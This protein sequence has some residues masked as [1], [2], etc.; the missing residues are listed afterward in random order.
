MRCWWWPCWAQRARKSRSPTGRTV[1]RPGI[2]RV[3]AANRATV[4]RPP[5]IGGPTKQEGVTLQTCASN[6]AQGLI[7]APCSCEDYHDQYPDAP[8]RE[9]VDE[10]LRSGVYDTVVTRKCHNGGNPQ[11]CVN[12]EE[13]LLGCANDF[14]DG[15]VVFARPDCATIGQASG[16]AYKEG[17]F[18][19]DGVIDTDGN[20]DDYSFNICPLRMSVRK[21]DG[22]WMEKEL[23]EPGNF[24]ARAS[25]G[26]PGNPGR[27]PPRDAGLPLLLRALPYPRR[28]R[29]QQRSHL[30]VPALAG[31]PHHRLGGLALD[32]YHEIDQGTPW[33]ELHETRITAVARRSVVPADGHGQLPLREQ[34]LPVGDGPASRTRSRSTPWSP[35]RPR[36]RRRARSGS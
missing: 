23:R 20:D 17:E 28:P 19:D 10:G 21:P 36:S 31:R 1:P 7:G 15:L 11:L 3:T 22:T 13:Q 32:R 9:E 24:E 34:R 8:S 2:C 18:A 30:P 16:I 14:F 5:P 33:V 4:G 27:L 6:L 26:A 29:F 35:S 12:G 25:F